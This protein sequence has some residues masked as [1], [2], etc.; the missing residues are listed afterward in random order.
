MAEFAE[1]FED[2]QIWQDARSLANCV[3]DAFVD[4]RDYAFRDQIQ[5]AATSAMNNIAEG[6][7]RRTSKDFGHFLD[8]AKGSSGE[9]RSMLYLAEDR[10]YISSSS[11]AEL[12]EFSQRR[13]QP[14]DESSKPS[15]G[16]HLLICYPPPSYLL[17]GEADFNLQQPLVLLPAQLTA[18]SHHAGHNADCNQRNDYKC[19]KQG[20][21][22]NNHRQ[23]AEPPT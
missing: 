14:S 19:A 20:S 4:C 2:L 12:R 13:S 17:T 8:I 7:E 6:F 5:R 22:G 11:G 10:R 16:G 21:R 9:V 3:Y 18:D 1:R 15:C 23:L